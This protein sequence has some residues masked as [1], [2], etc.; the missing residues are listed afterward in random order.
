MH[1]WG[2]QDKDKYHSKLDL[3]QDIYRKELRKTQKTDKVI[4]IIKS[5]ENTRTFANKEVKTKT[6]KLSLMMFTCFKLV[7]HYYIYIQRF[8]E[9]IPLISGMGIPF[10][11]NMHILYMI[12]VAFLYVLL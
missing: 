1:W 3:V 2:K 9:K 10:Q 5:L 6:G 4:R 8:Q 11:R 7:N 12:L